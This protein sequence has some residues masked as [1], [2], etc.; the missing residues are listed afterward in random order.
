[1]NID[2]DNRMCAVIPW[3]SP[4]PIAFINVFEPGDIWI[5]INSCEGCKEIEKCCG[6]C[7]ILSSNGC[8]FHTSKRNRYSTNKP[9]QCVV[10][11]TPDQGHSYCQLEFEC[12]KGSKKGKIRRMSD[13][14]DIIEG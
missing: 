13:S 9:Y 1:M 5:K 6:D 4:S 3:N 14:L 12:I 11:P 10:K 7:P 8:A 2:K